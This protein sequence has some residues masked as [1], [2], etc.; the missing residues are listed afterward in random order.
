MAAPVITINAVDR[1]DQFEWSSLRKLEI[2]TKEPNI[3]DMRLKNYGAKT[4]KPVLNDDVE[5]TL[6]GIKFFAGSVVETQSEIEG[7]LQFVR[8]TFK[9][10]THK[11]DKL[12]VPKRY[13][14]FGT[15]NAIIADIITNFT[16]P[17]DAFTVVNV[18]APVVVADI[19]FNYFYVSDALEKLAGELGYDWYVDYDKDINFFIESALTAPFTLYEPTPAQ[20]AAGDDGNFLWNSLSL[21]ENIHQLRN[22]IIVRGGTFVGDS[23]VTSWSADGLQDLFY[24]GVDHIEIT[25]ELNSVVQTLGTEGID[26]NDVSIATLYNPTSGYIRFKTIP[27][28]SDAIDITSKPTFPIIKEFKD[29]TSI[30]QFGTFEFVIV[31]KSIKSSSAANLKAQSELRKWSDEIKDLSFQTYVD[32]LQVGQNIS[33]ILPTRGIS[34]TFLIKRISTRARGPNGLMEYTVNALAS[35]STSM[36]DVLADLLIN[37]QNTEISIQEGEVIDL[38]SGYFESIVC[39]ESYIVTVGGDVPTYTE[40]VTITEAA[41]QIDH[42]V[43]IPV[44]GPYFPSPL[45]TDVNRAPFADSDVFAQAP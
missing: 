33:V 8:V 35:E 20:L 19:N 42:I 13:E 17:A 40:T 32:G 34:T 6:N 4:Y 5:I 2:L 9:D 38:V 37:R 45:L 29:N 21:Q 31:D 11:L 15:A 28:A 27:T 3:L 41:Y 12:L 26:D 44:A 10:P 18:N 30:S 1:S 39:S 14:A 24:L 23:R 7:Q 25:V 36:V 43:A 16:D 22:K